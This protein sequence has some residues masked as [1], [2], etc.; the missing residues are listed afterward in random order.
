MEWLVWRGGLGLRAAG[1]PTPYVC[2]PLPG[3]LFTRQ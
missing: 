1:T 2:A 3:I